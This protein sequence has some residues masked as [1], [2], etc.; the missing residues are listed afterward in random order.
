MHCVKIKTGYSGRRGSDWG[1]PMSMGFSAVFSDTC[2]FTIKF[3][4]FLMKTCEKF[5]GSTLKVVQ[6]KPSLVFCLYSDIALW[7]LGL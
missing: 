6:T 5:N 3:H 1:A 7:I 4:H 2:S